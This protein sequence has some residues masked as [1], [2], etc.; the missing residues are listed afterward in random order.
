M[1]NLLPRQHSE[2][3]E[4]SY[5]D[6]FFT[7][8]DKTAFEWY[9]DYGTLSPLIQKQCTPDSRILIVG[10]GNSDLSASM[11]KS[12]FKNIT[13]IDFSALVIAEMQEKYAEMHE[14]S[15]K[16]MDMTKLTRFHDSSFDIVL[17]KGA[18][19]ALMAEET[20]LILE[21]ASEMFLEL[22]RVL[23]PKGQYL[24]I[25]MAQGFILK[26][27]L[28]AFCITWQWGVTVNVIPQK[29]STCSPFFMSATK[30]ILERQQAAA[31]TVVKFDKLVKSQSAD[32]NMQWLTHQIQAVQWYA[33][34]AQEVRHI[35][36]GR[37]LDPIELFTETAASSTT[38]IPRYTLRLVDV[39]ET[40]SSGTCGVFLIP[41][42]REH[43]WVFHAKEGLMQ[44]AQG[45]DY[46]RLVVVAL[47]RTHVFDS[48]KQVQDELSGKIL[49]LVPSSVMKKDEKV[50]YLTV[51]EGIGA[52]T[53]VYKGMSKFS[54]EFF[55]EQV[56]GSDK[57]TVMRRLI[58]QSNPNVIQSEI[59]VMTSKDV[60]KSRTSSSGRKK[61]S[62]QTT[63]AVQQVINHRVLSFDY[64]GG[65]VA[66]ITALLPTSNK[67]STLVIGLGGGA[68]PMHL[69][70]T[71]D[72]MQLTV[73]ELDQDIVHVA[74]DF[75]GF[76]ENRRMQVTVGDGLDLLKKN[77]LE[78]SCQCIIVDVDAKDT[79]VGMSCPPVAFVQEEFL[80]N[81]YE[82]L[83]PQGVLVMNISS[84]NEKVYMEA[85]ETLLTQFGRCGTVLQ[86]AAS[87]E[88]V[89]RVVFA[90]KDRSITNVSELCENV[91]D[92]ED[93]VEIVQQIQ[94]V[95][96]S[97]SCR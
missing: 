39:T 38:S 44:L 31:K 61:K 95:T 42:G 77:T 29:E 66:G 78:E 58:F 43:E 54:G 82:A 53:I 74:T 10:C 83:T 90:V 49:E 28:Q 75:F 72:Q 11:Y 46:S 32:D 50:P 67:M 59:T 91:Q 51:A 20:S 84:R 19:D 26:H 37:V 81:V 12:G 73:C 76:V 8:R 40:G 79:S 47:G 71:F 22:K 70:T 92:L 87:E 15:W 21:N 96:S 80:T 97:E 14:M 25:S 89:N 9:G 5:W 35:K 86:L 4:R 13:N 45:A 88:D 33:R 56:T 36:V 93:V 23:A 30:P 24:C 63:S 57:D 27:F 85:L 3:R 94:I 65:M 1:S 60:V 6:D 55:V 2:F 52:R 69:Y 16:T 64:H 18:L 7:K 48:L 68:L 34:N 62:Q 41:Q 17:D